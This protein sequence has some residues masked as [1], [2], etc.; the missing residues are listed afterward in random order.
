[1]AKTTKKGPKARLKASGRQLSLLGEDGAPEATVTTSG[2]TVVPV[3]LRGGEPPSNGHG[4]KAPRRLDAVAMGKLQREISVSEFFTKNR[5]LLGFDNPR[6]ALLTAVKEAVDNSL[7]A[8]EDAGI[9]PELD[10]ALTQLAEDRFHM[11]VRDNG[12]GIVEKQIP[13]VFGKLLYGSK[14]HRYRQSRGQQ[15]I[16]ISAAGMYGQLTTGKPS[17]VTSRIGKGQP[18]IEFQ[19]RIDTQKNEPK[20]LG[21]RVVDVSYEHGTQV[22]ITM[23]A[24]Y[25]RG[26]H[27]VD[28]FVKETAIAN[29][30][31]T[32]RYVA[33]DGEKFHYERSAPALP[34]QPREIRPHPRGVELG[35][36]LRMLSHTR[37]RNVAGFL[38]AEFSRVSAR[39]AD[40]ICT[41]AKVDPNQKPRTTKPDDAERLHRA[42]N[43]EQVRIMAPPTDCVVPIGGELLEHSLKK[44]LPADFYC[45]VTRS[46]E[47]YRGNPFAIEAGIAFGGQLPA[48]DT[49][50]LYRYANRVP[51][52]YQQ[53]ACAIT[54]AVSKVDWKP[55]GLQQS[56]NNLPVGPA[57]IF[58]HMASVW[59]PFTSESKEAVASYPEIIKEIR[60]ALQE[61]GRRLQG[62]VNKR[63]RLAYEHKRRSIFE[64]YIPEVAGALHALAKVPVK[65]TI[66][67]LEKI[68]R[69][70]TAKADVMAE[71]ET[72]VTKGGRAR[73]FVRGS[74]ENGGENGDAEPDAPPAP[75]APPKARRK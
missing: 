31:A 34:P 56:R 5:H 27:S 48:E 29:P 42:M 22:E 14:F 45:A 40:E 74:G 25:Q 28:S 19:I 66:E 60:L 44:Q 15:G 64:R 1:M 52:L 46:P 73:S 51:L 13:N 6:K 38:K 65:P 43:D 70:T 21:K 75:A 69:R 32:I 41:L 11:V 49:I 9:L 68:K 26:H 3:E 23:E 36:L 57:V 58:V 53:G 54:D 8:C 50:T 18:A 55:Y 17:V 7:D 24:K 10:I 63:R 33:P 39:V 37:S 12:P 20:V 35:V 4:R 62:F 72:T 30:H 61:C 67:A 16:G 59:V 2:K 71:D 47:V